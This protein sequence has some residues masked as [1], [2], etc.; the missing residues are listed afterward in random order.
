MGKKMLLLVIISTFSTY[1]SADWK[2]GYIYAGTMVC[3]S[4]KNMEIFLEIKERGNIRQF[5]GC[6]KLQKRKSVEINKRYPLQGY[7]QI[8]FTNGT[9]AYVEK[10]AV[11]R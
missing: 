2:N 8:E 11:R 9:K 3:D 10:N 5:T 1:T 6:R 7:V 4:R